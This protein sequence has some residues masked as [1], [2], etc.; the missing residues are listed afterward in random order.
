MR[1]RAWV[2]MDRPRDKEAE[3]NLRW[4]TRRTEAAYELKEEPD[5]NNAEGIN[6]NY[7]WHLVQK[8]HTSYSSK[9][10]IPLLN[11]NGVL[12]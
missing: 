9:P 2:A 7:F 4:E 11:N 12:S 1:N 3:R 5:I 10:V 6:Q 8:A